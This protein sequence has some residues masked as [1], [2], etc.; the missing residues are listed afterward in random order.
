MKFLRD[1]WLEIVS[2]PNKYSQLGWLATAVGW[3]TEF[4]LIRPCFNVDE[5][6]NWAVKRELNA[7][8][9]NRQQN[10]TKIDS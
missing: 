1:E 8:D 3:V 9:Q 4:P 5:L 2:M 6:S 7:F 10:N